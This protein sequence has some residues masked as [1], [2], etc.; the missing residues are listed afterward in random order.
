MAFFLLSGTYI[1]RVL[2]YIYQCT[3]ITI[4]ISLYIYHYTYI[5]IHIYVADKPDK[6]SKLRKFKGPIV[7]V[8]RGIHISDAPNAPPG[9]GWTAGRIVGEFDDGT[10]Q[11]AYPGG[12]KESHVLACNVRREGEGE[13]GVGGV[14]KGSVE[15]SVAG[16]EVSHGCMDSMDSTKASS[17]HAGSINNTLP[18][19]HTA[20]GQQSILDT[21]KGKHAKKSNA[22]DRSAHTHTASP[23]ARTDED[24]RIELNRHATNTWV[25]GVIT[26]Q[27]DDGT[28]EV[29]LADGEVEDFVLAD[30]I[31]PCMQGTRAVY[32]TRGRKAMNNSGFVSV[33]TNVQPSRAHQDMHVSVNGEDTVMGEATATPVAT[34]AHG[35]EIGIKDSGERLAA[36]GK[37]G[38]LRKFKGPIVSVRRGR[39][40]SDADNA[41]NADNADGWTAG[42]IVGEFDDGTYQIAY[43]GGDKESYV[44]AC[45]VRR[46]GEG[47][48]EGGGR[49]TAASTPAST[50]DSQ[51]ATPTNARNTAGFRAYSGPV[52]EAKKHGKDVW[53]EGKVTGEFADGSYQ[54]TYSSGYVEDHVPVDFVHPL[55]P[56]RSPSSR[57]NSFRN[58]TKISEQGTSEHK[59][60]MES[61][62]STSKKTILKR[63]SSP[64]QK[65]SSQT[66]QFNTKP[67][68]NSGHTYDKSTDDV[69]AKSSVPDTPAA[70]DMHA[71]ESVLV[72][73]KVL[74]FNDLTSGWEEAEVLHVYSPTEVVVKYASSK[75]KFIVGME[76]IHMFKS[77]TSEVHSHTIASDGRKS[78]SRVR[79]FRKGDAVLC[80][81]SGAGQWY[82]AVIEAGLPDGTFD[83]AYD[84]GDSESRVPKEFITY[85][86]NVGN[87]NHLGVI[88]DSPTLK[89]PA[90][91]QRTDTATDDH[92][93]QPT[94]PCMEVTTTSASRA[95]PHP[96]KGAI[97]STG[98]IHGS[99]MTVSG[100]MLGAD[101]GDDNDDNDDDDNDESS[102][103]N[104]AR[105]LAK[106]LT[107]ESKGSM[108][109]YAADM[110]ENYESPRKMGSPVPQKGRFDTSTRNKEFDPMSDAELP[111]NEKM[112]DKIIIST[113]KKVVKSHRI[114]TA[115]EPELTE[116]VVGHKYGERNRSISFDVVEQV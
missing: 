99:V 50:L 70:L 89:A 85:V 73:K 4:R 9:D 3:Y 1:L 56:E 63:P 28:Y 110:F 98:D 11:I 44:L 97:P 13:G 31:R 84:M 27:Y 69:T 47:E 109:S 74:A 82:H 42:R 51:D 41:D 64:V 37:V 46:E 75:S 15:G 76:E 115:A 62:V 25:V 104:T 80:N 20:S 67:E 60:S 92:A 101:S 100:S 107:A 45:N 88:D 24:M 16:K 105:V 26:K 40:L 29:T 48:G 33:D 7:S 91:T 14:S 17:I 30:Y 38:K 32:G 71:G 106:V 19:S 87:D 86:G 2:L 43:P 12:D 61:S 116:I 10:Y 6:V 34:P 52:V 103:L 49:T 113:A 102:V 94:M 39:Q 96:A 23:V 22:V 72:G 111:R 8:R 83:I 35:K 95:A 68:N 21:T 36:L 90:Y 81:L 78:H 108:G 93:T 114:L 58:Q 66:L 57:R 79:D 53:L 18:H 65:V 59:S 112:M 5:T 54:V 55:K 77:P